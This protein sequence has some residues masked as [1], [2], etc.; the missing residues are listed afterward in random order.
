MRKS[1]VLWTCLMLMTILLQSSV[2]ITYAEPLNGYFD[3][4]E[5]GVIVG[6]GWEPDSPNT[7]VPIHVTVTRE[8]TSQIVGDFHPNASIYREDL[9]ENQ[10]GH[11][12]HGF[13]IQMDW[14]SL[15]D[16]VYRIEGQVNGKS[17]GNA[18]SYVKGEP[19][20]AKEPVVQEAA[21]PTASR[22]LGTFRTTGYCS[23]SRCSGKWGKRTSTG[24]IPRSN[25]TVAVDPKVIPYGTK[26]MINGVVYTAE[27][28][29]SGVNG[30]HIDIYYDSHM[31]ALRHG[32][33]SAEVF[34]VP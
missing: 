22:S 18:L 13:R 5:D 33:R 1:K 10:I 9:S 21:L 15:P 17:F 29:G 30:K 2:I 3:Q 14:D 20:P 34:L 16:G 8:E 6:W 12:M 23:C 7:I 31:E 25:H 4:M 27:D 26:L 11:G 32:R 28:C 24:A 19:A